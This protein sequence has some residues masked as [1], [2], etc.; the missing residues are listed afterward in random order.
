MANDLDQ[1]IEDQKAKLAQDKAELENDPPYMEIR[2][3]LLHYLPISNRVCLSLP[4]SN[5][6]NG[7]N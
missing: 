5:I 7:G 2:V 4:S 6:S 3:R 1:F